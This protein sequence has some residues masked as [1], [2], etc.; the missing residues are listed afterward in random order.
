M[1]KVL[2]YKYFIL[3]CSLIWFQSNSL[4][5][6]QFSVEKELPP[7]ELE[8][9]QFIKIINEMDHLC[10]KYDSLYKKGYM[11]IDIKYGDTGQNFDSIT[12]LNRVENENIYEIEVRY[13]N[14][15]AGN[16]ISIIEINL[17]D[18]KRSIRIVGSDYTEIVTI[19]N[20]LENSFL[21]GRVYF[22]GFMF[23]FFFLVIVFIS[24]TILIWGIKLN[25][26]N[27]GKLPLKIID[28]SIIS[29]T[30]GSILI[31]FFALCVFN[32]INLGNTFPGFVLYKKS[33]NFIDRNANTFTFWGFVLAVISLILSGIFKKKQIKE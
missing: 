25:F 18:Y 6:N 28:P 16:T 12:D 20:H 19:I 23:R 33:A 10:S 17:D 32:I 5:C 27:K 24:S 3:I 7:F 22:G 4:F 26:S 13:S 11:S 30:I 31:I 21:N 29:A 9:N 2:E 15:Q 14:Y 8:I 1:N